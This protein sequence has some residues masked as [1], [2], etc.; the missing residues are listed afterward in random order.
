[1]SRLIFIVN[2]SDSVSNSELDGWTI[3]CAKHLKTIYGPLVGLTPDQVPDIEYG[4]SE[5]GA[6]AGA[7]LAV[8]AEHSDVAGA[9]GY[10]D[11]TPAG[12]P[13]TKVF[14]DGGNPQLTLDHELKEMTWDPQCNLYMPCSDGFSYAK[15]ACD[16][17]EN[18]AKVI[19]GQTFSNFVL[20]AFF[21]EQAPAGT[22]RD[23]L[24]LVT[25]AFQTRPGG[26][27][28]RERD[29]EVTQ[30]FGAGYPF[31]KMASKM[32]KAAR[33]YRRGLRFT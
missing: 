9:A 29:G 17:V 2:V 21:D 16:A 6:P 1:M 14:F 27:Q 8:M 31:R 7:E 3:G 10:H 30:V 23:W 19:D 12:L 20:D 28:I 15:E 33:A 25:R 32:H 13:Y 4:D 22:Q 18:D 11:I 5:A 24:G 26:Y